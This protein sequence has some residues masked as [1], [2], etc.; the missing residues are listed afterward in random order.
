MAGIQIKNIRKLE[1]LEKV[2]GLLGRDTPVPVFFT[3][4]FGIH[5]FGLKFPIDVLILDDKYR[6]KA[7][8]RNLF[9]NN[10]FFW[11][12]VYRNVLELPA[13]DISRM[14]INAGDIVNIVENN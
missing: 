5:T 3:T 10:L 4:R 13:G 7:V 12:P 14:G 9:P 8:K 6:V 2:T 1:G 11:P